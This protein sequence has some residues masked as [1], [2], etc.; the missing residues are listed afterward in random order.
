MRYDNDP[1]RAAMLRDLLLQYPTRMAEDPPPPPPGVAG[2]E[3]ALEAFYAQWENS[4]A[5]QEF[6]PEGNYPDAPMG[7]P[8]AQM[9]PN[10]PLDPEQAMML[11]QLMQAPQPPE[12]QQGPRNR[13][14]AQMLAR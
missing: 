8:D 11:Q 12:P 7:R 1:R 3:E 10:A 4:P 9:S 6:T 2:D 13:A 5:A 14:L